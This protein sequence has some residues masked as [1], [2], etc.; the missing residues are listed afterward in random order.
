MFERFASAASRFAGRPT[1]F[2]LAVALVLIWLALGPFYGWSD[3]HS[4]LINTGTTIVT[5]LMVFLVQATQN[6]DGAAIQAKLDELIRVTDAA[7][8]DLIGIEEKA[9]EEIIALRETG[10]P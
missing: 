2:L 3:H 9:A 8:N 4:M 7:R 5:F 10:A 1:A 6:R